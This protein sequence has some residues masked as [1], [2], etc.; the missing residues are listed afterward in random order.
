MWLDG[1]VGVEALFW[2]GVSFLVHSGPALAGGVPPRTRRSHWGM[3][4]VVRNLRW[5]P[6]DLRLLGCRPV[7]LRG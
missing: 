5:L 2:V 4:G 1:R 3:T 6:L 7:R